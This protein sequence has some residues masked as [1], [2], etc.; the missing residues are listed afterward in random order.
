MKKKSVIFLCTGNICRSPIGEALL[1][2]AIDGLPASSKLKDLEVISAGTSA[3]LGWPASAKSVKALRDVGASLVDHKPRQI[4]KTLLKDCFALIA[5]DQG[6]LDNIKYSYRDTLPP[7]CF[8]LM[9]LVENAESDDVLDPY[10]Y[11]QEIYNDVRDEI[12][13]AIAPLVKYLE[14]NL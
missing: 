11:S 6:H 2:H 5:M 3:M 14:E 7:H 9:S 10:G 8:K 4:N 1:R 12:M 13:T